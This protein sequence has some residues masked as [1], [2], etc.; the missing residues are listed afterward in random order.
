[1]KI[2]DAILVVKR[3]QHR[4]QL[5]AIVCDQVNFNIYNKYKNEGK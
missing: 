3:D 4:A 5:K 1:M 2:S